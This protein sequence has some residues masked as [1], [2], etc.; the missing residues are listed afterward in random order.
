MLWNRTSILSRTAPAVHL[1]CSSFYEKRKISLKGLI[2][3]NFGFIAYVINTNKIDRGRVKNLCKCIWSYTPRAYTLSIL[4]QITN[5][6]CSWVQNIMFM[7]RI[8][9]VS[10]HLVQYW[11]FFDLSNPMW[12]HEFYS[13]DFPSPQNHHEKIVYHS[14][15]SFKSRM[16]LTANST[17]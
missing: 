7:E 6:I 9:W 2:C 5:Q 13:T 4:L 11:S 10:F 3:F 14:P 8:F 16:L 17:W 12:F 1:K 15:S